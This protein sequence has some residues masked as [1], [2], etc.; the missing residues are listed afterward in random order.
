MLAYG[1]VKSERS[2][3]EP[4]PELTLIMR[5]V[6]VEAASRGAKVSTVTAGPVVL[7]RKWA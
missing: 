1:F 5:G 7:V 3:M 2:A 4:A 6:R